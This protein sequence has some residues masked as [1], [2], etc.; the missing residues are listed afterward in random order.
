[1]SSASWL[2][3]RADGA[4]SAVASGLPRVHEF[5]CYWLSNYLQVNGLLQTDRVL[6]DGTRLRDW[7]LGNIPQTAE[8]IA[9]RAPSLE[10]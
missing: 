8:L 3:S 6:H 4:S 2:F 9:Q 10:A 7:K 5:Q 1:M